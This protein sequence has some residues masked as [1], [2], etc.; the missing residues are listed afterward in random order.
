MD[1]VTLGEVVNPVDIAY[2]VIGRGSVNTYLVVDERGERLGE[3]Y[4]RPLVDGKSIECYG[5][6]SVAD[7]GVFVLVKP[8]RC[9]VAEGIRFEESS[10]FAT[11]DAFY[12]Y[13]HRYKAGLVSDLYSFLSKNQ[14]VLK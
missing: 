4:G 6:Y 2:P 10:S 9:R 1:E 14:I 5:Y 11:S 3:V 12:A 8:V 7:D 13:M